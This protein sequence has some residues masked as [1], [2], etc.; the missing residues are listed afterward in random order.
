MTLR[1]LPLCLDGVNSGLD[2]SACSRGKQIRSEQER[3]RSGLCLRACLLKSRVLSP[4]R[5]GGRTRQQ[6]HKREPGEAAC[7]LASLIYTLLTHFPVFKQETQ[8]TKSG[9]HIYQKSEQ[10]E[11]H[12]CEAEDYLPPCPRPPSFRVPPFPLSQCPGLH[13]RLL[14]SLSSGPDPGEW[15]IGRWSFHNVTAA[16]ALGQSLAPPSPAPTSEPRRKWAQEAGRSV[17]LGMEVE[18]EPGAQMCGHLSL[19]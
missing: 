19:G 10:S 6:I 14:P 7:S 2:R 12:F 11:A 16:K 13:S 17:S 15:A 8:I 1:S 3:G 5:E 4:A 9:N 18:S